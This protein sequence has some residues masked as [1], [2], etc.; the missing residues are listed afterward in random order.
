[1]VE[2]LCYCNEYFLGESVCVMEGLFVDFIGIVEEVDYE[3]GCI[4]VFVLIFGCV[5]FVEFEFN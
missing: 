5:I 2:K 4:K 3:K 1:M